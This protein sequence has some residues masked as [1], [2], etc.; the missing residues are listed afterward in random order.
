LIN[1]YHPESKQE[2]EDLAHGYCCHDKEKYAKVQFPSMDSLCIADNPSL[3]THKKPLFVKFSL[4]HVLAFIEEKKAKLIVIAHDI[5]PIE[6]DYLLTLCHKMGVPYVIMKGKALLGAIM[7]K[8]MAT[9]LAIQEVKSKDQGS[10]QHGQGQF[11]C[12][13][14]SSQ[15]V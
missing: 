9:V 3:R 8:K 1:K 5:D 10:W 11:V 6:L 13:F 15:G 14:A 2:K 7:H 12:V 4:N